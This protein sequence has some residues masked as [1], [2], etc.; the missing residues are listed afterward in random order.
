MVS[1]ACLVD[2]R[3]LVDAAVAGHAADALV[4]V[5]GVVEVDEVREVVDATSR[6]WAGP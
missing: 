4:H 5:D 2:E 6:G 1:G 3:H